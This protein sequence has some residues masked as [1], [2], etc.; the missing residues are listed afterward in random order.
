VGYRLAPMKT[1]P[2]RTVAAC[3][4]D[5]VRLSDL[6]VELFADNGNHLGVPEPLTTKL[7]GES[8]FGVFEVLGFP[9]FN[10][11]LKDIPPL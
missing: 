4:Q 8:L 11:G 10:E 5:L 1:G 7:D 3:H 9:E 2:K 6:F